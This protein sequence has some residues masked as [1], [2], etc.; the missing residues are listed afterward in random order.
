MDTGGCVREWGTVRHPDGVEEA[1]ARIWREQRGERPPPAGDNLRL[2]FEQVATE[3]PDDRLLGA[4]LERPIVGL[5]LVELAWDTGRPELAGEWITSLMERHPGDPGVLLLASIVREC[6]GDLGS[7]LEASDL[8]IEQHPGEANGYLRRAEVLAAQARAAT[9][10]STDDTWYRVLA[11]C[12][13]AIRLVPD[14]PDAH[15]D[16]ARALVALDRLDDADLAYDRV[17]SLDPDCVDAYAEHGQLLLGRGQF[18]A[19]LGEFEAALARDGDCMPALS[20]KGNALLELGSDAAALNAFDRAL[21]QREDAGARLGRTVAA[22]NYGHRELRRRNLDNMQALYERAVMDGEQAVRLD[23]LNPWAHAHLARALRAVG[24]HD[25]A[26]DRLRD[27]C[28]LAN[29]DALLATLYAEEGETLRLWGA[30][31]RDDDLLRQALMRLD[32]AA[33]L[34]SD[35]SER[36][37]IHEARGRIFL[38]MRLDDEALAAFQI[39]IA[40]EDLYGWGHVGKGIAL[41]RQGRYEEALA[42]FDG[43][44]EVAADRRRFRAWAAVG[45]FVALADGDPPFIGDEGL[46]RFPLAN[47]YLD[48]ADMLEALAQDHLAERDRIMALGLEP[49]RPEALGAVAWSY[50]RELDWADEAWRLEYRYRDAVERARRALELVGEGA[51]RPSY[52][53]ALGWAHFRLGEYSEAVAHL[54]EAGRLQPGNLSIRNHL[55]R[56]TAMLDG[57]PDP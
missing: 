53:H 3:N 40:I 4:L 18:S 44:D 47:D 46:P 39:S 19:A 51:S 36:A 50:L 42:V 11:D 8:L 27:A 12:D 32:Q 45:R 56:A 9:D 38:D 25:A 21:K 35:R 33:A 5:R 16:R 31:T 6:Q 22:I 41:I 20:G 52:V 48:R 24:A 10:G 23:S 57:A 15:L 29:D 30:L 13:E 26:V 49:D 34:S 1:V 17:V 14:R 43:L 2:A 54:R 28:R 55:E 7:A 37:W